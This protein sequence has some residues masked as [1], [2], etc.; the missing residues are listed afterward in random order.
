M[1]WLRLLLLLGLAALAA[2]IS[3]QPIISVPCSVEALRAAITQANVANGGTLN[4]AHACLYTLTDSM[5]KVGNTTDE[6]ALGFYY[7][8]NGLPVVNS[9][10]TILG[11]GA[12]IRRDPNAPPFRLFMVAGPDS[13]I[14]IAVNYPSTGSL[15]LKNLTLSGGLARGGDGADGGGGGAGLGGAIA[16]AGDVRLEGVTITNCQAVGG[17]GA[18]GLGGGGGGLGGN[19]GHAGTAGGGGG[20]GFVGNGGDG[21]ADGAGGG[22]GAL[23]NGGSA[24]NSESGAGGSITSAT[25]ATAG[26]SDGLAPWE[27]GGTPEGGAGGVGGGGA[28]N[29][30]GVGGASGY[31][32]GAGG[33]T[34]L[35]RAAE[36][37]G[38]GSTGDTGGA[39]GLGGGGSSAAMGHHGGISVFGGGGAPLGGSQFYGGAATASQGGGGAGLGGAIFQFGGTLSTVNSTLSGN[40]ALGGLGGNPGQGLGGAIFAGQVVGLGADPTVNL[41]STTIAENTGT[42]LRLDRTTTTVGN[43]I[44]ANTKFGDDCSM[45][46][47]SFT[48]TSTN[49]I[50]KFGNCTVAR[51]DILGADP[52][53]KPLADNGGPTFTQ[54][55][56]P[57]SPAVQHGTC[58]QPTDQR[59]VPRSNRP[60][61]DIGAYELERVTI[62]VEIVG[63][64]T[65]SGTGGI[66]CDSSSCTFTVVRGETIFFD[67]MPFSGWT[68]A[69]WGAACSGLTDCVVNAQAGTLVIATFVREVDAGVLDGGVSDAVLADAAVAAD[70]AADAGTGDAG[71][72]AGA[73]AVA[74]DAAA[75]A[76]APGP[77]DAM[78]AIDAHPPDARRPPDAAGNPDAAQPG[79]DAQIVGDAKLP[80]TGYDAPPILPLDRG[81]SCGVG[82]RAPTEAP[83]ALF[84]FGLV[85]L[86]IRRTRRR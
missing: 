12:T 60:I 32:G 7:G 74:A 57:Q 5:A 22:G 48:S 62:T 81:C 23:G 21:T 67:E 40:K 29:K 20:G 11:N 43:T 36:L 17:D 10:I 14:D 77:P 8:P 61:C 34:G 82:G 52:I 86:V 76:D 72:G 33:G 50:E 4:L 31:G 42:A 53:L 39:A 63:Q 18:T 30:S 71:T 19:G 15:S 27:S 56:T 64:G 79:Y 26:T 45:L 25:G 78:A 46:N 54:A 59:G 44:V 66:F 55:L 38:G 85:A 13:R 28:G 80:N 68:F 35:G 37:G 75:E 83:S 6:L 73:D 16:A 41:V 65:V 2:P 1:R 84:L 3:A 9:T 69:G 70:A 51:S 58:S 47:G 24:S 49:L